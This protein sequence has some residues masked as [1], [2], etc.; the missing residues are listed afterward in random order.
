MNTYFFNN[1]SKR[2]PFNRRTT[3][4]RAWREQ[5][6]IC[7]LLENYDSAVRPLGQQPSMEK[8][9][10]VVVTTSLFVNSISA[11]SERNM[12]SENSQIWIIEWEEEI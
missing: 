3:N 9:G 12:V 10:P 5:M 8:R 4:Y 11:V 1:F 6:T 7:E 2:T